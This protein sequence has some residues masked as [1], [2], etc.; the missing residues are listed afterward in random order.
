MNRFKMFVA[1]LLAAFLMV[2]GGTALTAGAAV[3]PPSKAQIKKICNTKGRDNALY[4]RYCM[5]DGTVQDAAHIW[6]AWTPN[7]VKGKEQRDGWDKRS[8]CKFA[9]KEYG[10]IEASVHEAWF[11][12]AYDNYRRHEFVLTWV[13]RFAKNDCLSMGYR[14]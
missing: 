6:Y 13:G 1:A 3:K 2:V 14:V 8:L 10:S 5:T 12:P 11:D 7:G 9:V 4:W